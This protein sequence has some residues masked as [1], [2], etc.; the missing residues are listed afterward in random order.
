MLNR[1]HGNPFDFWLN[2]SWE[3]SNFYSQS[4][5]QKVM[6]NLSFH[7]R[8]CE[9]LYRSNFSNNNSIEP[10]KRRYTEDSKQNIFLF[11]K[12]KKPTG[13]NSMN[14]WFHD[15]IQ[16]SPNGSKNDFW[17]DPFFESAVWFFVIILKFILTPIL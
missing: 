12:L 4:K 17:G 14:F 7:K 10:F 15:I 3:R 1:H 13:P 6:A 2:A 11:D 5:V 16:N 8:R 9:I